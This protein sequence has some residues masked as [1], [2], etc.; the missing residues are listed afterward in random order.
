MSVC[1]RWSER[2]GVGGGRPQSTG[3]SSPF[4]FP[5]ARSE[6]QPTEV[7]K[8]GARAR[9]ASPEPAAA[10]P[11]P[12]ALDPGGKGATASRAE[13]VGDG[14]TTPSVAV[15]GEVATSPTAAAD[16]ISGIGFPP[17][18]FLFEVDRRVPCMAKLGGGDRTGDLRIHAERSS[19]AEI[20]EEVM[21]PCAVEFG[22]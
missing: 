4:R 18:V 10:G 5:P 13:V 3:G 12:T 9:A 7:E 8:R 1:E 17:V 22:N 21:G 15:D 14:A 16:A 2:G 6:Q 19:V 20:E 11:E